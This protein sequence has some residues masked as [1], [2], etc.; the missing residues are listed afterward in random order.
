MKQGN[1]TNRSGSQ[2]TAVRG[3]LIAWLGGLAPPLIAFALF[4]PTLRYELINYDLFDH[5]YENERIRSLAPDHLWKMFTEP[6]ISYYPIRDLSFAIDYANWEFDP[7]GYNLS[8]LLIHLVNVWLVY[9]LV[10]RLF[11]AGW[12]GNTIRDRG[13]RTTGIAG[14]AA[15]LFA[16][17]PIVVEPVCWQGAREELLMMLFTLLTVHAHHTARQRYPEPPDTWKGRRA[18]V[19]GFHLIAAICATAACM[20]SA[21]G[22]AVALLVT[23]YE[24]ARPNGIRLLR[25][26]PGLIPLWIISL[27]TILIKRATHQST[28]AYFGAMA[29]GPQR[30]L[31]VVHTYAMNVKNLF[32]PSNL[33]LLYP[34]Y[35]PEG[36]NEPAVLAGLG[37]VLLTIGLLWLFRG[38]KLL[39]FALLWFLT[40]LA[41]SAQVIPH[42]IARADRFLYA[43]L[44]GLTLG[45]AAGL[46]ALWSR[47]RLA[48][49]GMTVALLVVAGL[50]VVSSRRQM[51]HWQNDFTLFTRC[52]EIHP[53]QV[54]YNNR[55]TAW[56]K[57]SQRLTRRSRE[58]EERST[59]L[60]GRG[61]TREA[62]TLRAE[63]QALEGEAETAMRN[64]IAD[65]EQALE[66]LPP[67]DPEAVGLL[68][69]LANA[70]N[71]LG[72]HAKAISFCSRGI[73]VD[74]DEAALRLKRGQA[75]LAIGRFGQARADFISVL[76]MPSEPRLRQGAREFLAWLNE[77][78]LGR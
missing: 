4:V 59:Q 75:Y 50:L 32:W 71:A 5:L 11:S 9:W 19:V 38:Y 8:N 36:L 56:G 76:S 64:A 28:L 78:D 58:L 3:T 41:P 52:I 61:S 16:V 73:K 53:V 68:Y 33:T 65:L 48:A 18:K 57:R 35:V 31:L 46:V 23:G 37:L 30:L 15:V 62:E 49:R 29:D 27:G 40:T 77:R 10:Q 47:K 24:L 60:A 21:L 20:S 69:N 14:L 55:G 25:C 44:A 1:K 72:D 70:S 39:L 13:I 2:D 45:V 63:A 22:A 26:L 67:G 42:Q 43:P 51:Q 6:H 66:M 12:C 7:Y 74:P 34:R 17:H 54:A